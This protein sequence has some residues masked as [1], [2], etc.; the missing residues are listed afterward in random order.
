MFLC[1]FVA[2]KLLKILKL[3]TALRLFEIPCTYTH[4]HIFSLLCGIR[5]KSNCMFACS[6][7]C[8]IEIIK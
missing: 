3:K 7:I 4:K 2:L 6:D 5:V 8:I 1:K